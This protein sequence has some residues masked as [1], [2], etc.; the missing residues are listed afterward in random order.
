[1]ARELKKIQFKG[2]TIQYKTIVD[3]SKTLK[4]TRQNAKDLVDGKNLT[5][6]IL[7]K[8]GNIGRYNIKT[9]PLLFQD[10]DI[11]RV[12]NKKLFGNNNVIKG[13]NIYN[14]VPS[15][16]AVEL[17]INVKFTFVISPPDVSPLKSYS[18]VIKE[19]PQNINDTYIKQLLN[20]NFFTFADAFNIP[21][22]KYEIIAQKTNQKFNIV[23]GKLRN[24]KLRIYSEEIDNNNK[25]D[26]V[27]DYL[28]EKYKKISKKSIMALGDDNGVSVVD[29]KDFC[30]KYDI[31]MVCYDINGLCVDSYYPTNK[32]SYTSLY[33]IAYNGHLY[34]LN[35]SFSGIKKA[36]HNEV[37][38][39]DDSKYELI[40]FLK[41]G[42][43]PYDLNINK[44]GD[45]ISFMIEDKKYI[46]N[47]DYN[48]CYRILERLGIAD[49]IFDSISIN[50]ISN[51]IEKVY[52]TNEKKSFFPYSNQFKKGAFNYKNNEF[53]YMNNKDELISIDKNKSY[54]SSLNSLEYVLTLD[55]R[56]N[57]IIKNP[58]DI[59]DNYLY[60]VKPQKSSILL[61]DKN[62][63][64]GKFLIKCKDEGLKFELLVGFECDRNDNLYKNII[65]DLY[66][67][68]DI[69]FNDCEKSMYGS[70]EKVIKNIVN[71]MIGKMERFNTNEMDYVNF[72]KIVSKEDTKY[73]SGF[74]SEL[75]NEYNILYQ[76]SKNMSVDCNKPISIQVKDQSRWVIYE[77][78]KK[79]GLNNND[80]VG[81]KTDSIT[82]IKNPIVE[83]KLKKLNINSSIDGWKFLE[84]EEDTNKYKLYKDEIDYYY[85][86]YEKLENKYNNNNNILGLCYAGCGKTTYIKNNY[87]K[88]NTLILCPSYDSLNEYKDIKNKFN[89]IE[90]DVIQTFDYSKS[91]DY[92]KKFNTVI[93]DE[94]GM[95]NRSGHNFMYK[96][97]LLGLKIIS[98]GDF[99]QMYPVCENKKYNNTYYLDMLF[100]NKINLDVNY[101]NKFTKEYYD[102]LINSKDKKYLE[103]EIKKV[104]SGDMFNSVCISYR[105]ETLNI[106]NKI[107]SEYHN[108]KNIYDVGAKIICI[109]NKLKNQDIT[110]KMCF[111]VISN[112]NLTFTLDNG[113]VLPKILSKYF[114]Y[115]YVRT[116]H[117]VQGKSIEKM[118]IIP[119][120][121]KYF[122]KGHLAYTLI[123][124]LKEN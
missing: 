85:Y 99:E 114:D 30:K 64:W 21:Y 49:K 4:I 45:I 53:D 41:Q 59:I 88:D 62:L 40:K 47:K 103:D 61:P 50:N 54:T 31:K 77:T 67:I 108:I 3:L 66:K 94:V 119:D 16:V 18:I 9:K 32:S 12:E 70:I 116:L 102:N 17:L 55:I 96:C 56:T 120:D 15:G 106:Y 76:V 117:S 42:Y 110:N 98:M 107:I 118:F 48:I 8:Q 7:D 22:L 73:Y 71:V 74:V 2:K 35:K 122:L 109:T 10:F 36:I 101:R 39:I 87:I 51:I 20:D 78:M 123:S 121:I 13:V 75:N 97:Y 69:Q 113:I 52:K 5:K 72:D 57:K 104:C 26:C 91:I 1:M 19:D 100:N 84:T 58:V 89:N 92:I 93:I 124:R 81:I 6:Y 112:D 23:N 38:F 24:L 33:F 28:I 60:I 37:I 11:K 111:T 34:G 27:R 115:A 14:E 46:C 43:F 80:I 83:Q 86:D 79:L 90:L 44:S 29:I 95:V 82:F 68:N 65:T 63:Y 25:I 105:R